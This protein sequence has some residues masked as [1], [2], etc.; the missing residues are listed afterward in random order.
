MVEIGR[1]LPCML[2]IQKRL[3]IG[4]SGLLVTSD[5]I[6]RLFGVYKDMVARISKAELT[7][8]ILCIPALCGTITD[9]KIRESRESITHKDLDQWTKSY[10]GVTNATKRKQFFDGYGLEEILQK[11]GNAAA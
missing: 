10:I 5:I 4:Q 3:S 11:A 1:N 6:E 9:E 7:R 8:S 2:A